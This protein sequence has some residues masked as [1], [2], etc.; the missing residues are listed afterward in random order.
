MDYEHIKE[1]ILQAV[2]KHFKPEFLNR[3]NDV[4]I[5]RP[6]DR[7]GLL[8][9]IEIEVKKLL[10]RLAKKDIIINLDDKAKNFLV[11]KGFQPEMG[12]RPLRRT[13]EEHLED[14]L[15]EKLLTHPTEGRRC[16]V[17]VEG[18]KLVFN[19]LEVIDHSKDKEVEREK[20][21]EGRQNTR[22]KK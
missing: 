3:L 21:K 6:L 7:I 16:E 1:K 12:A 10:A 13:I 19:D 22:I 4:V 20:D 8:S 11:E 5:F 2:K 17:T 18:D 9:V 14:P 15:A